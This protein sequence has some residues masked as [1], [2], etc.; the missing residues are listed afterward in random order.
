[1]VEDNSGISE[2]NVILLLFIVIF[3]LWDFLEK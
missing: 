3:L 1:M 2:I